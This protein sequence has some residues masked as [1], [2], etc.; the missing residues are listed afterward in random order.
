MEITDQDTK[1]GKFVFYNILFLFSSHAC[2]YI[3]QLLISVVP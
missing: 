2:N 3:R 1:N